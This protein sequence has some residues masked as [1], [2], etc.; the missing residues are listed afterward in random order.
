MVRISAVIGAGKREQRLVI[1]CGS[2]WEHNMHATFYCCG[3]A[4]AVD[5]GA[6]TGTGAALAAATPAGAAAYAVVVAACAGGTGAMVT[7]AVV[8]GAAAAL[9]WLDASSYIF[10]L[11]TMA[12]SSSGNPAQGEAGQWASCTYNIVP[13]TFLLVQLE[14]HVVK[15][16]ESL[17]ERSRIQRTQLCGGAR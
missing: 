9:A 7:P 8:V 1:Q 6:A 12:I 17:G 5:V 14:C 3:G 15:L 2:E 13:R 4:E 16:P 11:F 10:R